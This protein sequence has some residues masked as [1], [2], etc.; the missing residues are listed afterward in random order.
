VSRILSICIP[1]Y[2]RCRYLCMAL[3]SI[4]NSE[5]DYSQIEV[6]ISNNNSEDDYSELEQLLAMSPRNL[7][8]HYIYQNQK[9]SIDEN[10]YAVKNMATTEYIYFL[11]D[12][13]YFL[14]EQLSNLINLIYIECPDLAVFNGVIVDGEN[15]VI[16]RHFKLQSKIYRNVADAFLELKD[17]CMFGAVLVRC[18]LLEDNYF[19]VL[20][21]TSHGYGCF[22]LTILNQINENIEMKI[23]IPEFPLVALRMG[24][25]S[26]NL[27]DVYYRDIPYE[28]AIYRRYLSLGAPQELHY[29]FDKAYH[30]KISSILFLS[31]I[32]ISGCSIM[33]LK[34]LSPCFY[35]HTYFKVI[36]ANLLVESGVFAL[37]MRIYNYLFRRFR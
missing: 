28:I 6:C 27:L 4:Y 30:K 37:L 19:K 33:N 11:G 10:M 36:L 22:W 1:T 32:K 14:E 17:K 34:K 26:Y 25:K 15:N 9:K 12:D 13:D 7:I 16:K 18:K 29:R 35:K 23:M 31:K 21:G 24:R 8:V 2:N 20:F 3:Q 5:I